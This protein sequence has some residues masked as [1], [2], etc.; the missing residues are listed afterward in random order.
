[1]PI[2]IR[3]GNG[4]NPTIVITQNGQSLVLSEHDAK[5]VLGALSM[6]LDLPLTKAAQK[7]IN[8]GPEPAEGTPR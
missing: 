2:E 4:E 3:R 1:M 6:M 7:Q 8:L 5:R